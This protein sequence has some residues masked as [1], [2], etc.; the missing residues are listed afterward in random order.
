MDVSNPVPLKPFRQARALRKKIG[1][2]V[3]KMMELNIISHDK[4][5]WNSHSTMMKIIPFLC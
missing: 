5:N 2:E 1:E 3:K 4:S